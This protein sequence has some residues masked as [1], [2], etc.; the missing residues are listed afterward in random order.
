MHKHTNVYARICTNSSGERY[1]KLA[2]EVAS[3]EGN[4]GLGPRSLGQ[5]GDLVFTEYTFALFK[6]LFF[7]NFG[8]NLL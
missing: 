2:T 5:E 3:E 6:L 4:W 1:E 7:H 8:P